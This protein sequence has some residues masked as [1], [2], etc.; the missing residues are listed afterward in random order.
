MVDHQALVVHTPNSWS[1]QSRTQ[2]IYRWW[3]NRSNCTCSSNKKY[4]DLKIIS[5]KGT[6]ARI[7]SNKGINFP[8]SSLKM[9]ALTSDDIKDLNFVVEHAKST[10]SLI[11]GKQWRTGVTVYHSNNYT[12]SQ[13]ILHNIGRIKSYYGEYEL[14][15]QW[16]LEPIVLSPLVEW[17]VLLPS[18]LLDRTHRRCLVG[19]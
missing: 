4:L 5:P 10:K 1:S 12:N 3:E 16:P 7:K 11:D 13:R 9:P 6:V 2:N 18:V 17:L 15:L 14:E 19:E 8:D